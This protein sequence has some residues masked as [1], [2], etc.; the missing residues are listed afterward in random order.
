MALSHSDSINTAPFYLFSCTFS[1]LEHFNLELVLVLRF[2]SIS[3]DVP[4]L[5]NE[6]TGEKFKFFLNLDSVL[7]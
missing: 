6:K 5:F 3:I 2:P 7:F 4:Y 1:H